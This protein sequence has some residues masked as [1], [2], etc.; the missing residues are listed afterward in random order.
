AAD[1]GFDYHTY[2]EDNNLHR[3]AEGM[4]EIHG[5]LRLDDHDHLAVLPIPGIKTAGALMPLAC[6]M[7]LPD[8][9]RRDTFKIVSDLPAYDVIGTWTESYLGSE[10]IAWPLVSEDDMRLNMARLREAVKAAVVK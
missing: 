3:F 9:K 4:V 5:G 8:K 1:P 6:G 10:R 7:H 2:A